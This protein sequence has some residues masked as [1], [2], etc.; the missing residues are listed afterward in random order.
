M[1]SALAR[2]ARRSMPVIESNNI[3]KS[4]MKNLKAIN[5]ITAVLA[6]FWAGFVLLAGVS[7]WA[8][9]SSAR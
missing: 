5:L 2:L 3:S 6:V 9:R 4:N 1:A 7:W 8:M